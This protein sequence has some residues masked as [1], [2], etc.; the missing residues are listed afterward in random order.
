MRNKI[1][2]Y[3]KFS[4]LKDYLFFLRFYFL[5]ALIIFILGILLGIYFAKLFPLES[6]EFIDALKK[7]LESFSQLNRPSQFFLIL[8]NNSFVAF[9]TI[10]LGVFFGFIPFFIL[11]GNGELFGM[12][13]FFLRGNLP[14]FLKALLPHGIIELPVILISASIGLKV[15]K[16]IFLKLF[17]KE[18][19]IKEEL[20][21]GVEFFLKI[22]FPLLI[23]ASLCEVFVTPL[24]LEGI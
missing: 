7:N 5:F 1:F 9:F 4:G 24:F 15:G 17:K 14:L 8:L 22:L 16:N 21:K 3:F 11:I 12:L 10:L 19:K 13:Y 23:I 18:S 2:E 6:K 20:T